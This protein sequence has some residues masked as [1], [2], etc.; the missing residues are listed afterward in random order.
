MLCGKRGAIEFP[1]D[2]ARAHDE[3]AV[4]E[5][6]H[7]RQLGT[8]EQNGAALRREAHDNLADLRLGADIDALGRLVEN[9]QLGVA[10]KPARDDDLLLIAARQRRNGNIGGGHADGDGAL[11]LV[12]DAVFEI[13]ADQPA[14]RHRIEH[15]QRC[16]GA[17]AELG[18][19]SLI[20]AILR[21]VANAGRHGRRRIAGRERDAANG[22]RARLISV[23]AEDGIHD[24]A[25]ARANEASERHDLA[26]PNLEGD[27]VDDAGAGQPFD[28]EHYWTRRDRLCGHFLDIAANHHPDH[29]GVVEFVGALAAGK[30]AIAQNGDAVGNREDLLEPVRNKD[31][32]EAARFQARHRLEQGVDLAARQ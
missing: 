29:L 14:R 11:R 13:A 32:G 12:H 4:A 20:A 19:Q 28:L 17:H 1:G 5:R 23:Y 30:A 3:D 6:E 21:H 7:F 24:F 16:I 26:G 27:I 2:A 31:D 10:G 18:D 8:D 25:A 15:G 9:Q 22:N